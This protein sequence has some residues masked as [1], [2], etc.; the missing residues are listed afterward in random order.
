MAGQRLILG[1]CVAAVLGSLASCIRT[2]VVDGGG[3]YGSIFGPLI[4]VAALTTILAATAI[5]GS[6][7]SGRGELLLLASAASVLASLS[8]LVVAAAINLRG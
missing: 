5:V 7:R 4:F 2:Y 3:S 8:I 1:V 6:W